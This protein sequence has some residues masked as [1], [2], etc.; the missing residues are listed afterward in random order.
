MKEELLHFIWKYQL[1]TSTDLQTDQGELIQVIHQ[2]YLNDDAGPD[3]SQ[4]RIKIGETT[5]IGNV[6]IHIHS[7][8]WFKH[9]HH[10][11][12]AYK[13]VILHVVFE[14]DRSNKEELHCPT[15]SISKQIDHSLFEHYQSLMQS[16]LWIPCLSQIH[17]VDTITKASWQN[18]LMVI[19]LEK[20]YLQIQK[21]FLR[22][23]SKS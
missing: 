17:E 3:F 22:V 14:N 7:S 5:W 20:R 23:F 11:D 6:E 1:F 8:D 16:K 18:R 15:L 4:A 10:T 9:Q 13:S 21:M 12:S 2:G 19:R